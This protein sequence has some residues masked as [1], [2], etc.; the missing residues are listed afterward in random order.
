ME[1]IE[2]TEVTRVSLD[3]SSNLSPDIFN[4]GI[5]C[6]NSWEFQNEVTKEDL[7]ENINSL[8]QHLIKIQF[9]HDKERSILFQRIEMMKLDKEESIER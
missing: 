3:L 7:E 9:E 4:E 1:E 5:K 2:N 8:R 6:R